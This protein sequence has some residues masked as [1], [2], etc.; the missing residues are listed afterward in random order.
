MT[1]LCYCTIILCAVSSKYCDN[2]IAIFY[3]LSKCDMMVTITT[4][5]LSLA[6]VMVVKFGSIAHAHFNNF[7]QVLNNIL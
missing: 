4:E 2:S 1:L 5:S 6:S 7:E 3:S